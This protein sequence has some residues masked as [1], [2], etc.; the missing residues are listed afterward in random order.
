MSAGVILPRLADS[1]SPCVWAEGAGKSGVLLLFC[2]AEAERDLG[3]RKIE[4]GGLGVGVL[5]CAFI[6]SNPV[7]KSV[8]ELTL[9]TSPAFALFETRSAPESEKQL[10]IQTKLS[11]SFNR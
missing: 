9:A 10:E 6:S 1:V 5:P 4:G 3:V 11:L 7:G 8:A 2:L